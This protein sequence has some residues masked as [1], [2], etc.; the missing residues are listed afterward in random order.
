[1]RI[2]SKAILG[3]GLAIVLIATAAWTSRLQN[4]R[5]N[6]AKSIKV[7]QYLYV[8]VPGIRNYLEYGGHG[9][10]QDTVFFWVIP[11]KKLLGMFFSLIVLCVAAVATIVSVHCR[12]IGVLTFCHRIQVCHPPP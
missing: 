10:L 7:N 11:W 3:F 8:A 4:N 1:M 2:L 9:T 6:R 5:D 12:R